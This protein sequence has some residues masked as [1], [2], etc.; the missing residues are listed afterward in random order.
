MN[1]MV[2]WTTVRG[3]PQTAFREQVVKV[4]LRNYHVAVKHKKGSLLG[5]QVTLGLNTS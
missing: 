5:R 2:T 4:H 1:I 3:G